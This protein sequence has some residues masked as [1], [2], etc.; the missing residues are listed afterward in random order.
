M[1][2]FFTQ[3][4]LPI[5]GLMLGS[6]TLGN[7]FKNSGLPQ[8]WVACGILCLTILTLVLIKYLVAWPSAMAPTQDPVVMSVLPNLTMSMLLL[9]GYLVGWGA[10]K[11]L[12]TVIWWF[13]VI[14][15]FIMV[16][17]FCWHHIIKA[18]KKLSMVMPSW[19]VTFVGIGVIPVTTSTFAPWLGM[20]MVWLSLIS[21]ACVFP[22]VMYR[23]VK[24]P[25]AQP[26]K[27][28]RCA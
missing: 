5:C 15:Q 25:L 13:A 16:G 28:L 7:L 18:E 10:P 11:A 8:L 14:L 20:P 12:M 23:L 2:R 17:Y 27:P 22:F 4:P 24:L 6:A 26:A 3:L 9:S 19:F 21:Y 1:R